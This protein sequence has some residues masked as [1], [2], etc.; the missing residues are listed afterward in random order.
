MSLKDKDL[1]SA[2]QHELAKMMGI[3]IA[4]INKAV[5]AFVVQAAANRFKRA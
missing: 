2:T 4:I 3:S 1:V 5:R